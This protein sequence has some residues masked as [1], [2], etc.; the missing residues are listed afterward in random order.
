MVKCSL[1]EANKGAIREMLHL[2]G[3][4]EF[5]KRAILLGSLLKLAARVNHGDESPI[6]SLRYFIPVI[7]QVKRDDAKCA[8][9]SGYWQHVE[10]RLIREERKWSQQTSLDRR[11]HGARSLVSAPAGLLAERVA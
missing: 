3:T 6:R 5:V 8:G 11:E 1:T 2:G 7:D 9:D 4:V 10:Q